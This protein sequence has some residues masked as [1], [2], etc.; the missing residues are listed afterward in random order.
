MSE[1]HILLTGGA[2]FIG[3][4]IIA[5]LTEL[6]PEY[7]IS[8]FDLPPRETWKVARPYIKYIQ[9]DVRE[10]SDC[11]RAIQVTHPDA[12]IHTAGVVPMGNDRYSQRCKEWVFKVN[13]EGTKNMLDAAKAGG[14]KAFVLTASFTMVTEHSG[15][16]Y[17]NFNETVPLS[18]NL[19]YGQS[20]V[21]PLCLSFEKNSY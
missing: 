7:Q 8:V 13:V 21:T 11:H 17:P 19:V 5:S 20:K 4:H 18:P 2:G 9:G 14:V 10:A 15:H 12:I 6:H 1:A 16:D 3:S